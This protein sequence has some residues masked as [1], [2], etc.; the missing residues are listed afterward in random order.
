MSVFSR[1]AGAQQRILADRQVIE[2][3]FMSLVVYLVLDAMILAWFI[4]TPLA[5]RSGN[6]LAF[7]L[8]MLGYNVGYLTSNCHQMPQRSLM[9]LNFQVP[10][11]FRD[12]GIY[13]G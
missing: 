12:T 6:R 5:A 11:C 4:A 7:G 1:I 3:L 2:F 9:V 13:A 10:F 8:A